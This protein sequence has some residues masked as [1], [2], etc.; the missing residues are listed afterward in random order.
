M[1]S[2]WPEAGILK[3]CAEVQVVLEAA[4]RFANSAFAQVADFKS[5]VEHT[6]VTEITEL[7]R[8]SRKGGGQLTLYVNGH[9]WE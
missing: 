3:Y 5:S 4:H 2:A 9:S 7:K 1:R 6:A 8:L